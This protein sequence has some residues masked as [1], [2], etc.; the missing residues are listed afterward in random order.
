MASGITVA[1]S[2]Q[3]V[4]TQ[5]VADISEHG[6][7]SPG[8]IAEWCRLIKEAALRSMTPEHVLEDALKSMFRTSYARLVDN[9]GILQHHHGITR[10]T[11]ERVKP[12]LRAEL[13]RAIFASAGLIKLNKSR[14]TEETLQRF[15]GWAS[16]VQ[17][18]GSDVV[19]KQVVK[20]DI[21]K[22]LASLPY[23]VRRCQIDQAGKFASNLSAI[24]AKDRNAIAGIWHHHYKRYPR[25]VHVHRDGLVYLVRDSWAKAAGFIKPTNG[26][27]DEIDRPGELILCGC[28]YGWV[29]NIRD[30]PP[31]NVT[32]KGRDELRRV[33]AMIAA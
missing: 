18:G 20:S 30:L 2:F 9:G 6:Y 28:S 12:K 21:R 32:D 7:M 33:R 25:P 11:L 15:A 14:A 27:T 24:I 26:Y 8:Q 4:I 1:P 16:S 3:Q 23:E 31:A 13:D 5:A 19:K 17:P 10:F 29:Y 22:A